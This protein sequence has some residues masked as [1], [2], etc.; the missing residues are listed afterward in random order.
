MGFELGIP[1]DADSPVIP[2]GSQITATV[3]YLVPPSDKSAYYGESDYLVAMS[4]D[5]YQSTDMMLSLAAENHLT[6]EASTG[7]LLR[8]HPI[9]LQAARGELAAQFTLEGGLGYTPVTFH[10]LA[11]PDGWR[12]ERLV[13][14]TW[15][16]VDQAVEGNDFWQAYDDASTGRFD[17]VFNVHNRGLNEYRLTR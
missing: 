12:L 9:E 1:Y 16:Q 10:G 5:D 7:S 13:D 14:G 17:L 3:E 11:R 4:A 15:E 2:A 8:T 6:V